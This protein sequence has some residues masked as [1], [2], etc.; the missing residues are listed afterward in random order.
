MLPYSALRT[1][2]R[3]AC[4]SGDVSHIHAIF[5]GRQLGTQEATDALKDAPLNPAILRALLSRGAD[6]RVVHIRAIPNCGQPW[7]ILQ[8]LAAHGYDFKAEG[9]RILE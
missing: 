9:H 2:F 7:E 6:A 8:I 5:T 4:H 3:E 1:H